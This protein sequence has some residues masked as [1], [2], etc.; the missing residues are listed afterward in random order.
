MHRH[1]KRIGAVL[2][3]AA[4]LA[5]GL[6]L[7]HRAGVFER[8]STAPAIE[9]FLAR[10]WAH[11]I[12]PQGMPPVKLLPLEASLSPES[13]AQCHIAQYRDW[14]ESL[15]ARSIG[16]GLLWQFHVMGQ[17]QANKCL[18]CHAPLAEQKALAASEYGW[19]SSPSSAPPSYVDKRLFRQGLVCAACHVRRHT[20]YGPPPRSS[21]GSRPS[22]QAAHLGFVASPAFEDSRFC[23]GCH[24]FPS[25][26]PSLNGKL[27]ENTFAEWR[28]SPFA[29]EGKSCQ[30][31]HMPDRRH[32]WRGI[33][34][35]E[36]VFRGLRIE[37]VVARETDNTATARATVTSKAVGH[38]FPTYLVPKVYVTLRLRG[39]DGNLLGELGDKVIGRTVDLDLTHELADTRL[40]PGE[41]A[42]VT[43]RLAARPGLS[44]RV[45]LRIDVAPGEHYERIF[46][47]VLAQGI[48]DPQVLA[49]QKEALTEATA[50]RY[51]L[52]TLTVSIP[53]T[54]GINVSRVAN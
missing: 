28:D 40:A 21:P 5:A 20:R 15:H 23:A 51:R 46:R 49:L 34:D 4:A 43:A 11:P 18:R 1:G 16:A 38:Y 13:C 36:M 19:S 53:A 48:H 33:H 39:P 45:E 12:P 29:R 26:G 6:I 2:G 50:A 52:A 14:R 35:R 17:A 24:Q 54:V 25:D 22:S 31:C 7:A 44:E 3:L 41:S 30:S 10:Y 47:H 9:Q 32:L 37:L 8:W 42:I 27:L